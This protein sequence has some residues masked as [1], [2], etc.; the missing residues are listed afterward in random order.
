MEAGRLRCDI[1]G[2]RLSPY[3][4]TRS[5]KNSQRV[6]VPAYPPGKIHSVGT[7][8]LESFHPENRQRLRFRQRRGFDFSVEIETALQNDRFFT[9]MNRVHHLLPKI[10]GIHGFPGTLAG[11][12]SPWRPIYFGGGKSGS[13]TSSLNLLVSIPKKD[14]P[15]SWDFS[16]LSGIT[17]RQSFLEFS[18]AVIQQRDFKIFWKRF[19]TQQ[20]RNLIR[21]HSINV[22]GF[23]K[24]RHRLNKEN[25]N[26]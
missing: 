13:K 16:I 5:S 22:D 12:A 17:G 15:E 19:I 6:A 2:K 25:G 4:G 21:N 9:I 7:Q 26:K 20:A 23:E 24:A 3:P 18:G 14:M 1:R 11:M 8:S 10:P